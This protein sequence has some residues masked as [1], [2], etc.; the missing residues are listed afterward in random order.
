MTQEERERLAFMLR[1]MSAQIG[2]VNSTRARKNKSNMPELHFGDGCAASL[3]D[4]AA[5]LLKGHAQ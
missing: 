2:F 5:E 4:I 3:L 1:E